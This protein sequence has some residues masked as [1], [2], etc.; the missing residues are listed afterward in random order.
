LRDRSSRPLH[1]LPHTAARC[2]APSP[3]GRPRN[4]S[5]PSVR[6]PQRVPAGPSAGRSR[7]EAGRSNLGMPIA[8]RQHAM[9]NSRTPWDTRVSD[10]FARACAETPCSPRPF[11]TP[12]APPPSPS[13]PP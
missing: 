8:A 1:T 5:G 6:S 12:P 9:G 10:R 2:E 4:T 11:R 3:H 13:A 7:G